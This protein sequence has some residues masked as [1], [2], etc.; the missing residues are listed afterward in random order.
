MRIFNP[1]ERLH[2]NLATI[3][4]YFMNE[5]NYYST[6]NVRKFEFRGTTY[7]SM[8]RRLNVQLVV[9]NKCPFDCSF[10]IE[11]INPTNEKAENFLPEEQLI[12]LKTLLLAIKQAGM[13]PTVSIT[14]GEPTLYLNHIICVARMLDEI[15][16][17][18]NLNTAG[19]CQK[20]LIPQTFE[21]INLSVHEAEAL[22]NSAVFGSTRGAY[23][24]EIPYRNATI[25]KVI[26]NANFNELVQF[27]D[28]FEQKRYSIRFI[29][30]TKEESSFDW[31]P[32]FDAIAND[33]RFIFIQQKIGD[34]YFFEEYQYKKTKTVRFSFADMTQLEY[35]KTQVEKGENFVRAVVVMADGS[36]KFDWIS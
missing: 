31:K 27:L 32:L 33:D 10:C 25:Q 4:Y 12:S 2:T 13:E 9:T 29:A 3:S 7:A 22:K 19:N 16:V 11:K 23:W 24:Q 26:T 5:Y 14:G 20:M 34:Y 30:R 1:N 18:Y 15:E 35:Y 6:H 21:R 36:V 17:K 8:Y 28:S